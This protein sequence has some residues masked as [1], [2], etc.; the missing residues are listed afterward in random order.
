VAWDILIRIQRGIS[1]QPECA[2]NLLLKAD[3]ILGLWNRED[4]ND[5]IIEEDMGGAKKLWKIR[6]HLRKAIQLIDEKKWKMARDTVKEVD[7]L[8]FEILIE[9]IAECACDPNMKLKKGLAFGV[10]LRKRVQQMR[11]E[12]VDI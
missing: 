4:I 11:E 10:E 8:L 5:P 7:G 3:R 1:R 6:L 9:R 12:G 2:R